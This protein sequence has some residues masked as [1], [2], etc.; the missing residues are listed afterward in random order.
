M[1]VPIPKMKLMRLRSVRK[2]IIALVSDSM[3]EWLV[4]GKVRN[5]Y[6]GGLLSGWPPSL[7][8]AS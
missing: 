1:L 2:M 8:T 5:A 6:L 4:S 7:P 3:E